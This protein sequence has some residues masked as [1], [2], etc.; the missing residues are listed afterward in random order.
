MAVVG[1]GRSDGNPGRTSVLSPGNGGGEVR[2]LCSPGSNNS[3]W[4]PHIK[5]EHYKH[6]LPTGDCLNTSK[7]RGISLSIDPEL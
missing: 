3:L 5:S 6:I 4:W 2:E 1:G 7:M